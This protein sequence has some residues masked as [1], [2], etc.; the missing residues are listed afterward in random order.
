MPPWEKYRDRY[1]GR[2]ETFDAYVDVWNRLPAAQ[3]SFG[4]WVAFSQ[5]A[6]AEP[7]WV[8]DR[9]ERVRTAEHL[10]RTGGY[11]IGLATERGARQWFVTE[12]RPRLGT[13][14]LFGRKIFI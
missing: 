14:R 10:M 8:K 1:N 7:A 5:A 6:N 13:L 11:E 12:R 2:P 3:A 4:G 9:P